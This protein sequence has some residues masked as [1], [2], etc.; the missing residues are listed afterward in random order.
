M[1]LLYVR[2]LNLSKFSQ[3]DEAFR[4]RFSRNSESI[5]DQNRSSSL[6]FDSLQI[7]QRVSENHYLERRTFL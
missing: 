1:V 4:A 6:W 3:D 7:T 5:L 2:S